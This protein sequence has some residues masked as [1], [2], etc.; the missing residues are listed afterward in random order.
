MGYKNKHQLL[1][2][3]RVPFPVPLLRDQLPNL[4]SSRFPNSL[5][6]FP[7]SHIRTTMATPIR[8]WCL[9]ENDQPNENAA[10]VQAALD[11]KG[12]LCSNRSGGQC[13]A[14]VIFD[15]KSVTVTC[16]AN[17][18]EH[19]CE[20][21]DEPFGEIVFGV[22]NQIIFEWETRPLPTTAEL[23]E[24]ERQRQGEVASRMARDE[25]RALGLAEFTAHVRPDD[26]A[27]DGKTWSYTRGEWVRED[28]RKQQQ[29]VDKSEYVEVD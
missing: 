6:S 25:A 12:C 11:L 27:P 24:N 22:I 13:K 5:V 4:S 2:S 23:E 7:E 16:T 18:E 28:F 9:G 20:A 10:R 8:E 17:P 29:V 3:A 26:R 1:R 15:A 21:Y 14:P 19:T